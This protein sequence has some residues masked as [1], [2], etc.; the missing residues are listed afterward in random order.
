MYI[1]EML[2]FYLLGQMLGLGKSRS[3]VS[4]QFQKLVVACINE[5]LKLLHGHIRLRLVA[6]AAGNAKVILIISMTFRQECRL[7][8]DVINCCILVFEGLVT[9][10]ATV[11]GLVPYTFLLRCRYGHIFFVC[12]KY[13]FFMLISGHSRS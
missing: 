10:A 4:F 7:R 9:V 1:L 2:S 3:P 11:V 8:Y 6:Y 12:N 5:R 13:T